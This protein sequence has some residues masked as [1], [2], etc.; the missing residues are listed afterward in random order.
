[1]NIYVGNLPQG[2]TEAE[3]ESLFTSCGSVR[4]VDVVVN[5]RSGEQ[6]GYAFVIMSSEE[7][8]ERVI[9]TLNGREWNG[10][11]LAISK[12]NRP[13]GQRISSLK[14]RRKFR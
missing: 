10:K 8:G 12:A 4:G 9:E 6:L 5:S 7:E 2:T 1:M 3:L 13:G 11:T 14:R